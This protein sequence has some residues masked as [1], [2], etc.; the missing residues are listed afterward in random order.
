MDFH[1]TRL[2]EKSIDE[3]RSVIQKYAHLSSTDLDLLEKCGAL[4]QS[5]I[6]SISENVIGAFALPLGIATHFVVNNRPCLIPFVT[7]EASVVAA[8]SYAAKLSSGFTAYADEPIMNGIVQLVHVPDCEKAVQAIRMHQAELVAKANLA[9]PILI[10]YGGGA[11]SLATDI[12]MTSRGTMVIVKLYVNVHS[13]MGASCVT[14]MCELI[15]PDLEKISGGV[16]RMAII[17]NFAVERKAYAQAIWSRD[18]LGSETIENILDAYAFAYVDVSRACT[19]NKGIMNGIDAVVTATGNDVRAVEAGA[20][21]WAARS[22]IYQPLTTFTLNDNHD[23]LGS[24]ELPLA[25]GIVGGCTKVHPV[26]RLSLKILGVQSAQE[27]AALMAAV[28]L[29]QNFAALRA[30]V[31]EGIQYGHKRLHERKIAL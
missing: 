9:D 21:V 29:A 16:A 11:Y 14:T 17:N 7:E 13:A 5:I 12:I 26:A 19:H 10:A 18:A 8:A 24:I 20:H 6:D 28:G 4:D 1:R 23:L 30:L 27:L 31:C 15:A 22:G 25:V 3:R 2:Y